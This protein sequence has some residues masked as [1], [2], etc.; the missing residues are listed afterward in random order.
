[1]MFLVFLDKGYIVGFI[2]GCFLVNVIGLYGVF[3]IIFG[4]L[5]IFI[6]VSMI[7][8]IRKLGK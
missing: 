7:Y 5:V 8:I 1:M 4:I 3:D 6:S 2:L